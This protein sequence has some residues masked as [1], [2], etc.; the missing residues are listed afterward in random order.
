MTSSNLFIKNDFQKLAL[1][2]SNH[3]YHRSIVEVVAGLIWYFTLL[4]VTIS[5][6]KCLDGFSSAEI[7]G[8]NQDRSMN[9]SPIVSTDTSK[10]TEH[11]T[12]KPFT[13]KI[14]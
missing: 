8:N 7:Y 10:I 5:A 12:Y 13:Q 11:T 3:S 6:R 9:Y 4:R 1:G 2:V 14:F